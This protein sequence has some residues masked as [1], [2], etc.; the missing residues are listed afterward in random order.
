VVGPWHHFRRYRVAYQRLALAR[1][2]RWF[3]G[4]QLKVGEMKANEDN[5]MAKETVENIEAKR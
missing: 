1:Q 2:H 4:W 5:E 3:T